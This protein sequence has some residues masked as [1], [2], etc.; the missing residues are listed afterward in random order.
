MIVH[1]F[2]SFFAFFQLQSD[3]EGQK[4][5]GSTLQHDLLND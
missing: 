4:H 5:Y 3:S 2:I 1:N